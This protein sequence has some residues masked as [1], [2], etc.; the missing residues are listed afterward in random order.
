MVLCLIKIEK[1]KENQNELL[2]EDLSDILNNISSENK[3]CEDN[4]TP[5]VSDVA[6]IGLTRDVPQYENS[7]ILKLWQYIG[8][9]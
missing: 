3:F 8:H 6:D 7:K 9:I 2:F 4:D 1:K 5:R